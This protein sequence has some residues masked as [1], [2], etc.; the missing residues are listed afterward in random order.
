MTREISP[1]TK[2]VGFWSAVLA[3]VLSITYVIGQLADLFY[4][5]VDSLLDPAIAAGFL[6]RLLWVWSKNFSR[7]FYLLPGHNQW[8]QIRANGLWNAWSVILKNHIGIWAEF[9]GKQRGIPEICE[10]ARTVGKD[11]GI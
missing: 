5:W 9:A 4:S 3:T 7:Q 8:K 2:I 6:R 11:L 10:N 1:S